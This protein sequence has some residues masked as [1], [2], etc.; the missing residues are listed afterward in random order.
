MTDLR[1]ISDEQLRKMVERDKKE[2]DSCF[3]H[4]LCKSTLLL[5]GSI[6]EAILVD[7][8]LAFPRTNSTPEQ[9]LAAPLANLIEWAEQEKLISQRTKEIS[10][11]IRNYRN[12]IHPGREYRLQERIDSHTATVAH[13]LVEII[14]QEISDSYDKKLGYTA[15]QAVSKVRVDP[16]FESI[17]ASVIDNMSPVERMRLF[18]TIPITTIQN[19]EPYVILRN[20]VKLHTM[21][22]KSIP[23]DV[24]KEEI[25]R[26]YEQIHHA[27]RKEAVFYWQFFV[28]NLDLLSDKQR[29]DVIKYLMSV[30]EGSDEEDL[31]NYQSWEIYKGLNKFLQDEHGLNSI[32]NIVH[33]RLRQGNSVDDDLFLTILCDHVLLA[34]QFDYVQEI[35]SRL[36][37]PYLGKRAQYWAEYIETNTL[38]F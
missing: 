30:L 32:L 38:P 35:V 37:M 15:E 13:S 31:E 6:V 12:L 33:K 22:K 4:N 11:V 36:K 28:E 8:F 29:S 14:I 27:P 20:F 7:F 10:T 5:S 17:F 2:L 18:R 16:S 23:L 26:T 3:Q 34:F 24:V 9:V 21:L 19:E 1:F 25:A